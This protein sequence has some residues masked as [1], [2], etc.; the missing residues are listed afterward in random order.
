MRRPIVSV[1]KSQQTL[2][3]NSAIYLRHLTLSI[4]LDLGATTEDELGDAV[5][6]FKE[7]WSEW[8][9]TSRESV[10]KESKN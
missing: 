9:Q 8:L 5:N 6:D 3:L 4:A 1:E 10:R 7:D 2:I